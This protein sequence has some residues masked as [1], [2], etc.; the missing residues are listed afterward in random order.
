MGE[1]TQVED[2]EDAQPNHSLY[3][4]KEPEPRKMPHNIEAEQALLGAILVNNSAMDRV[5][6]FL[7]DEHFFE[8]VHGRIFAACATLS[9]KGQ[10]FDPVRLKPF[11][12][13][14]E[15]LKD[16][17]GAT[18]LAKLAASAVTIINAKDYAETIYD[19][20]IR[21]EL[22]YIGEEAVN[23]AYDAPI[24][25]S[26]GDL[27]NDVD[28]ALMN[29]NSMG[30]SSKVVGLDTLAQDSLDQ[31]KAACE[32]GTLVGLTTGI[33]DLDDKMA[34][35]R[36]GRL[37]VLGGRPGM[38]KT[39]LA[40][41]SARA[42]AEHLY[43]NNEEGRIAF[44]SLEMGGTELTHRIISETIFRAKKGSVPY[45]KAEAGNL[46]KNE[47]LTWSECAALASKLPMSI[48]DEP[49]ITM[50][51]LR[52]L[53]RTMMSKNPI[54]LLVVDYLQLMAVGNRYQG[55]R[56]QEVSEITRGLKNLAREL[57]IP[58]LA[59]SQLS[60][61]VEARD[62]KRPMLSDLRESGTIEQDADV[63]MFTYRDVVYLQKAEPK[64]QS[65]HSEW[66]IKLEQSEQAMEL[67]VAKQ[68]NGATGKIDLFADM[69]TN[70]IG[71]DNQGSMI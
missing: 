10:R 58:I 7:T 27:I 52:G 65:K 37:Y 57:D 18:Y 68:R 9:D 32:G 56:V 67:D 62:N 33:K 20:Y 41:S 47:Q 3:A 64:D 50:P 24:D 60:R 19:L 13:N 26:A 42:A 54:K 43:R 31:V 1:E 6:G 59:L 17:G 70:S 15:A 30:K 21:R 8:P 46:N 2:M 69:K 53:C 71:T 4:V 61:Q 16:I 66:M 51:K 35:W 48:I 25:T 12:E 22:I 36:G 28:N 63:V 29:L 34:G 14:D 55:Q 23:D 44:L 11:F 49:M 38:G 39:A 45:Q 40:I 5:S